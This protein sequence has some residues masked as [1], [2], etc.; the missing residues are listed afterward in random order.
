MGLL[1]VCLDCCPVEERGENLVQKP[2][3][4]RQH[5][6]Y[7]TSTPDVPCSIFRWDRRKSSAMEWVLSDLLSLVRKMSIS[8]YNVSKEQWHY[9]TKKKKN[10]KCIG[11][12]DTH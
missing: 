3:V 1:V 9:Q 8:Y 2:D 12:L 5:P 6:W 4:P 11:V 10:W 7:H